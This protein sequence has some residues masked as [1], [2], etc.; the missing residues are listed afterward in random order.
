[1]DELVD[2]PC[3]TRCTKTKSTISLWLHV[4]RGYTSCGE[5]QSSSSDSVSSWT[6]RPDCSSYVSFVDSITTVLSRVISYGSEDSMLCSDAKGEVQRYLCLCDLDQNGYRIVLCRLQAWSITICRTRHKQCHHFKHVGR[7]KT[8]E[9]F[10]SH[11]N[12][13]VIIKLC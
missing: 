5:S 6:M 10:A 13:S 2:I 9:T 8:H 1:M 12:M 4:T 3:F 7:C 11:G